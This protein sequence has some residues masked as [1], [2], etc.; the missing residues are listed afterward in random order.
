MFDKSFEANIFN[1][2]SGSVMARRSVQ[3]ELKT[4]TFLVS[5]IS[6]A[7]SACGGGGGGGGGGISTIPDGDNNDGDV[8][9]PGLSGS[10]VKGPLQNASVFIDTD[11]DG[12]HGANDSPV[13]T[14]DVNGAFTMASG[15]EGDLVAQATADT[16]DTFA[17]DTP[18]DGLV[19]KAPSGYSVVSPATTLTSAILGSNSDL[20]PEQA[21]DRVKDALGLGDVNLETFNPFDNLNS[22]ASRIYERKAQQV[23][24]IANS[25]SQ[26]TVSGGGSKSGSLS[27]ALGSI[28]EVL[29]NN[30][31]IDPS[32]VTNLASSSVIG[33]VIDEMS[34]PNGDNYNAAF[35]TKVEGLGTVAVESMTAVIAVVNTAIDE[36]QDISSAGDTLAKIQNIVASEASKVAEGI[37]P[38]ITSL[39]A[40]ENYVAVAGVKNFEFD[41]NGTLTQEVTLAIVDPD[42]SE[43]TSYTFL[44]TPTF[45]NGRVIGGDTISSPL[46]T[47][48]VSAAGVV[49]FSIDASAVDFLTDNQTLVQNYT[50]TI[51]DNGGNEVGQEVVRVVVSGINDAPVITSDNS[52]SVS[53]SV[54]PGETF[55]QLT[56]SDAENDAI[57]LALTGD[58]ASAFTLAD[59]GALSF[60]ASP[61]FATKSAYALGVQATDANGAAITSNLVVSVIDSD[62]FISFDTTNDGQDYSTVVTLNFEDLN[63]FNS[64]YDL[65]DGLTGFVIGLETVQGWDVITG[66]VG[67]AIGSWT[68]A[69]P[70][71]AIEISTELD[72]AGQ[73]T[74]RVAVLSNDSSN[75][76][77]PENEM[78][79]G[80]LSYSVVEAVEDF[81]LTLSNSYISTYDPMVRVDAVDYTLDII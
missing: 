11:G 74:F 7:L 15:F 38:A 69:L 52:V 25:I 47:L 58:D 32:S 35:A 49:N 57:T 65:S 68:S 61:D 13:V 40:L 45:S 4:Q 75:I 43:D 16:V 53:E 37:V 5:M 20:T 72:V 1:V 50:L 3:F 12:V 55:L 14:T 36:I 18:L 78:V 77:G 23:I 2:V 63:N 60:V 22:E 24:S 73:T 42:T 76:A 39:D 44:T 80:T 64:E 48:T 41:E 71:D 34:D 21:E 54:E 10:V 79:L 46:G 31:Q 28:A 27:D 29:N 81:D 70:D 51:L 9:T 30:I 59:N 6:V 67:G 56:A 8:G 26:L 33:D 66:K 62:S 17:P 19:L